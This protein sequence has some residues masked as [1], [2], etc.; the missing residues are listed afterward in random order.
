MR[1][2][3]AVAL[4]VLAAA[5]AAVLAASQAPAP[6]RDG[7]AFHA[8]LSGPASYPGGVHEG[9]FTADAGTYR[10]S[11]VPSGSSPE[12]LGVSV[13]GAFEFSGTYEL[14]GTRAETAEYYTWRYDGPDV[15]EIPE[16]QEVSVVIDPGG[17]TGGSVS[18]FITRE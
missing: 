9:S 1:R 10:V 8:L 3:P 2:A 11:F 12:M 7:P 15:F 17:Q 16:A 6:D 13:S 4:A 5:A 18:V 14:V